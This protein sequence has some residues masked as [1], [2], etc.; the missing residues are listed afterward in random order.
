M[1]RERNY[2]DAGSGRWT[3]AEDAARRPGETVAEAVPERRE[4]P[5]VA[6]LR[7]ALDDMRA[8]A[9]R[10]GVYNGNRAVLDI[11]AR[12]EPLLDEL[13]AARA[14]ITRV[15]GLHGAYTE[16][17]GDFGEHSQTW[18]VICDGEP[19]PCPT[20]RALDGGAES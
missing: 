2:R 6:E 16:T 20:I 10:E 13:D 7:R 14:T 9:T 12:V 8:L 4:S 3:T 11:I 15:Q 18:C 19:Y 1:T 17:W 5:D